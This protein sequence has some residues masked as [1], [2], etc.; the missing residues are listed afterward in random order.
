MAAAGV[1]VALRAWSVW[2]LKEERVNQEG[3]VQEDATLDGLAADGAFAHS[4]PAQLAGAMATHEDHVLQSVQTHRTHGLFL[5][6]L[7]LLL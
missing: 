5:Y 7:K 6:I 4:V 2:A 1:D 3:L